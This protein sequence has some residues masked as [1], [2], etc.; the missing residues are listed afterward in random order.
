MTVLREGNLQI[1]INNAIDVRK[2]DDAE[3]G[4]SHCMNLPQYPVSRRTP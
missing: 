3:H 1:T 2:F 4:L